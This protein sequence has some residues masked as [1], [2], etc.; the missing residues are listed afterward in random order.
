MIVPMIVLP[1]VSYATRGT[2]ARGAKLASSIAT[3]G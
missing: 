2:E 1:V 3:E